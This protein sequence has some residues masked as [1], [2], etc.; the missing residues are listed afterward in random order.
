MIPTALQSA[1]DEFA[2]TVEFY[3]DGRTACG[4]CWEAA[5]RFAAFLYER[6]VEA[7]PWGLWR[8]DV[9]DYTFPTTWHQDSSHVV[10]AV[11]VDG[12]TFVVDW[13]AAQYGRD[14]FPF[15]REFDVMPRRDPWLLT[16]E[17]AKAALDRLVVEMAG[18]NRE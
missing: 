12:R 5:E 17:E 15:V 4:A 7:A 2:P 13:T 14:E 10:C 18:R 11:W 6:G 16:V 8:D 9:F 3:R 1:I